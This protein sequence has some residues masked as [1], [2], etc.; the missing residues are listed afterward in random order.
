MGFNV[1]MKISMVRSMLRIKIRKYEK[2]KLSGPP[3]LIQKMTISDHKDFFIANLALD[4]DSTINL[5]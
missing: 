4:L 3:P 2:V 5:A 1:N